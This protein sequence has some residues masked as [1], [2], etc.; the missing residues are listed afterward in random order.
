MARRNISLDD[1]RKIAHDLFMRSDKTYADI[2]HSVGVHTETISRWVRDGNWKEQKAATSITRE[3]VISDTLM[4]LH[5]LDAEIKKRTTKYPTAKEADIKVKL[6]EVIRELDRSI[7]LPDYISFSTE[8]LKWIS[9]R[10]PELAKKVV[11][12]VNEF[13][14]QK[15][16]L[17]GDKSGR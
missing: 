6:K 9:Q 13:V 10:N 14:Q 7:S 16:Q 5:E 12:P 1:K 11:D 3:Q 17:L 8:L 2:A 15:A 4:Q